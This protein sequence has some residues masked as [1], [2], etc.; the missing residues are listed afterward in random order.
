M[1][2]QDLADMLSNEEAMNIDAGML[3]ANNIKQEILNA[4]NAQHLPNQHVQH[5]QHH[6]HQQQVLPLVAPQPPYLQQPRVELPHLSRIPNIGKIT[7]PY[8]FEVF[9]PADSNLVVLSP[10]PKLYVKMNSKMTITTS[11]H[12]QNPNDQLLVRAMIIF[13]NPAEMNTPVKRCANHRL[14]GNESDAKNASILK[15]NDPKAEYHGQED[16][17]TFSERLSVVVPLESNELD[18]RGR[19]TQNIGLEF[20]CQNSCVSGINR[21]PTS[22]VFTL[23][24]QIGQLI[25]KSAIEVKVCSC[26]KRDSERDQRVKSKRKGGASSSFPLGKHPKKPRLAQVKVEPD[27]SESDSTNEQANEQSTAAD[28]AVTEVKLNFPADMVPALLENAFN[29]IAGKMAMDSK[30]ATNYAHM[31]LILKDLKKMIKKSTWTANASKTSIIASQHLALSI[32]S[33]MRYFSQN[34]KQKICIVFPMTTNQKKR[35]FIFPFITLIFSKTNI[36]RVQ[37]LLFFS[38]TKKTQIKMT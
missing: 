1:N 4:Y 5:Q 29:M 21:K 7:T 15:V 38:I 11:Y 22:I 28:F 25:G 35:R 8:E 9:V 37:H 19:I 23:E 2:T 26:P 6:H 20:G 31:E 32:Y 17:Q 33:L 36:H 10:P 24:N 16:G 14:T 27:E 12:Q 34:T 3:P 13:S 30:Q 18:D